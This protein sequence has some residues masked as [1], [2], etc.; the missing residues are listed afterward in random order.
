MDKKSETLQR[1]RQLKYEHEQS[2]VG[3][4]NEGY[5]QDEQNTRNSYRL[6]AEDAMRDGILSAEDV[7]AAGLP[8][9]LE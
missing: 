9:K 2:L 3:D 8:S 1:L 5:I 7:E 6:V 4:P